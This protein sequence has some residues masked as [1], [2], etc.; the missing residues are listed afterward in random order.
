MWLVE[1]VGEKYFFRGGGISAKIY[2][3]QPMIW[4]VWLVEKICEE[5]CFRGGGIHF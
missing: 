2:S 5:N 4:R 1:K 3:Y